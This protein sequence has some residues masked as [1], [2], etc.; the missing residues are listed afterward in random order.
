M[1]VL[2]KLEEITPNKPYQGFAKLSLGFFKIFEFRA[3]KNKFGKKGDGSMRSILIEL[4]DQVLFLPTYFNG[5]LSDGDIS[6][7]N[8]SIKKNENI[9]LHF[10]G[11]DET[12]K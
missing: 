9:Y 8:E 12:S 3:V 7:L 4:E 6:E 1:N 5:K 10:G 2:K 11:R